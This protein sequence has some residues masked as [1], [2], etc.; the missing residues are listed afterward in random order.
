MDVHGIKP[1]ISAQSI[2]SLA[3]HVSDDVHLSFWEVT[4]LRLFTIT[5]N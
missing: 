3:D 1:A 2:V 4:N 5:I